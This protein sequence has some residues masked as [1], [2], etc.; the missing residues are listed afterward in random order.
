MVNHS[1][2]T[3]EPGV[4]EKILLLGNN[5]LTAGI[6][7]NLNGSE[8]DLVLATLDPKADL[9]A[10]VTDVASNNK[11]I[12]VM[13]ES[14]VAACTGSVGDFTIQLNSN[15]QQQALQVSQIVLS[16]DIEQQLD[17]G[18]YGLQPATAIVPLTEIENTVSTNAKSKSAYSQAQT[19]VF[20]L[21]LYHEST[22][23]NTRRAMK[24]AQLSQEA[25][26][27]VY[28]LTGN[29][30]VG[31]QGLERLYRHARDVGVILIKFSHTRPRIQMAE[32]GQVVIEFDD[33]VAGRSFRLTPDLTIL[34]ETSQPTTYLRDLINIFELETDPSGFAQADNVHRIGVG[35]NR[36]GIL[37]AGPARNLLS[38]RE[39]QMDMAAVVLKGSLPI[40]P[41]DPETKSGAEIDVGSCIRCLTC[42]RMCP[43]GAIQVNTR[44]QVLSR[45]CEACG[46]CAAEC[47]REA[48]QVPGIDGFNA[49]AH[50]ADPKRASKEEDYTPTILAYCCSRSAFP[51]SRLAD[52][53]TPMMPTGL[54]II[55]IPCAGSLSLDHMLTGFRLGAD[56]TLVLTCHTDNCHARHGNQRA[57]ER[58]EM[59][60]AQFTNI[61]LDKERLHF[62]TLASNMG[63]AFADIVIEFEKTLRELGPS[64]LK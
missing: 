15:Q 12:Q 16:E 50:S 60:Q 28:I 39:H 48:I 27:Q 40:E 44:V 51:A 45:A 47:P 33:E 59:L 58:V 1:I 2:F 35:T 53:L 30:K 42:H 55:E 46:L 9:S 37:V 7:Q 22:P 61:G 23:E 57:L 11:K 31:D 52:C 13:T 54:K 17:Y 24:L 56:G 29:L 4:T 26:K 6:A 32:S 25:G 63:T 5:A 62:T 38:Q 18:A 3:E 20:L 10:T 41:A 43:H 34:D 8:V 49:D 36:A 64:K 19:L 14:R 21:G